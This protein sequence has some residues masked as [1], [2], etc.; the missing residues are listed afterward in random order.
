[1]SCWILPAVALSD[2]MDPGEHLLVNRLP[3]LTTSMTASE[4]IISIP[5]VTRLQVV[6]AD[7]SEAIMARTDIQAQADRP[8]LRIVPR[9]LSGES[10]IG[11]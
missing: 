2:R 3:M 5:A 7:G 10:G 9:S 8:M 1:M 11:P 6:V 4:V